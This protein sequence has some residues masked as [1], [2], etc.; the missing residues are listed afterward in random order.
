MAK[1]GL[2][3]YIPPELKEFGKGAYELA[4]T[5]RPFQGQDLPIY[6][7]DK[8]FGKNILDMATGIGTLGL[9]F[10][11]LGTASAPQKIA[12][13]IAEEAAKSGTK[14][15]VR[16]VDEIIE[17]GQVKK[18][19][20]MTDDP[21]NVMSI[22]RDRRD[23]LRDAKNKKYSVNDVV[24]NPTT[25]INKALLKMGDEK[26]E[27]MTI[28]E[29]AE[30]IKKNYNINVSESGLANKKLNFKSGRGSGSATEKLKEVFSS[31]ENPSQ[32]T[33][34][35]LLNFPQIKKVVEENKI[36]KDVFIQTKARLGI[37]SKSAT[38]IEKLGVN[39]KEMID[40]LK[41]NPSTT[42]TQL[43]VQFP[44]IKDVQINS[45][46]KWRKS[47]EVTRVPVKEKSIL[48]KNNPIL[49][50]QLD[51]VSQSGDKVLPSN[52]PIKHNNAFSEVVTINKK[53][54]PLDATRTKIV[55]AHGIGEGGISNA[56]KEII[57]SKVA[58]IPEKFLKE[59]EI[60]KFFLTRSG[61]TAHRDIEN[62]LIL[63]LVNKYDKLGYNF[64]EGAWKQ[65][66][67]VNPKSITKELKDLENEI[68]GY[69]DELNKLDAYTL[70]YN[71]VKDKM[72]THGKPLSKIPGLSNLLNQ[73]KKGT[74]KLKGGG[75]VG[76]NHLTRPLG[77]F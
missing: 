69:Q 2:G 1:K 65:T 3:Y 60:P 63:A 59:E 45:I 15:G 38:F 28:K 8:S 26:I 10:A 5:I 77:N 54:G 73:V 37:K 32:Y 25:P 23:S 43:R 20:K 29:A 34:D 7:S 30:Y 61:N 13:K 68:L 56:S 44:K 62:N 71:P 66:K 21:L 70:F 67:K 27:S 12:L 51:F 64:V 74:K 58:M 19:S 11:T 55:Q 75:L 46:D 49:Q 36:S 14:T 35:Q 31:I 18:A 24:K 39:E 72:V 16:T 33:I 76:I 52:I 42:S 4:K 48:K 50:S 57:K 40:F 47:N 41:E 53:T 6:D 22:K 17:S 9:D